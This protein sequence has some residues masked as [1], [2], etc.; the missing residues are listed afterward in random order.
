MS[1]G[2]GDVYK[3]Q[4]LSI[5]QP[6]RPGFLVIE[7]PEIA[8]HLGAPQSLIEILQT[9]S[10][11]MQIVLTTHSADIVDALSVDA[12]RVVWNDGET[13]HV[14]PV[15]EHTRDVLRSGLI[16]PGALLRADALDPAI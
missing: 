10:E 4:L 11:A 8:I 6:S 12:L 2:L 5:A 9:D 15:S 14:A 7:E 13:S 1:R 3:R 16:T